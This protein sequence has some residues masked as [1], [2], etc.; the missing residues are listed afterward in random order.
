MLKSYLIVVLLKEDGGKCKM[1]N[2]K[3]FAIITVLFM[4]IY[5]FSIPIHL[6]F[7]NTHAKNC[8]QPMDVTFAK[9][10]FMLSYKAA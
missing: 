4:C 2:K 5:V 6:S 9:I 10:G 1:P 3:D 8:H 7:S